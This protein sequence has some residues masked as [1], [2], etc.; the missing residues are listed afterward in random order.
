MPEISP[1]STKADLIKAYGD[2]LKRYEES[3]KGKKVE[4]AKKQADEQT[5]QKAGAYTVENITRSLQDLKL[6]L[7]K[8]VDEI[9]ERL[10]KEASIMEEI[11]EAATIQEKKLKE[12][13]D[14]ES[15]AASLEDLIRAHVAKKEDFEEEY[16]RMKRERKREE[17]EYAYM[18]AQ[19]RKREEDARKMREEEMRKREDELKQKEQEFVRLQKE[20]ESFPSRLE[21]AV[22]D[23]E[24]KREVEVRREMEVAQQLAM[25]ETE[26]EKKV[27]MNRI[28]YSE[29]VIAGQ[30]AEIESLKQK[31]DQ[32]HR[33][34]QAIAEKSLESASGKQTLKAVSDIAL[35]QTRPHA[36]EGE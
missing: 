26:G 4:Q 32:A 20:V 36:G 35:H 18:L 5:V 29:E 8:T 33:Q 11:K 2:V 9:A 30:R 7:G 10:T 15:A 23:A 31:L 16:E 21:K 34:V 22:A 28:Q 17:D 3:V 24:R 19:Q 27:S 12:L 25:K 6:E 14:I 13:Y 1:K